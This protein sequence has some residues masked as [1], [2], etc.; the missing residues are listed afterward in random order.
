MA[1][2]AQPLVDM[3]LRSGRYAQRERPAASIPGRIRARRLS[4]GAQ[5]FG[6]RARVAVA[7]PIPDDPESSAVRLRDWILGRLGR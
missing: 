6:T 2:R 1:G 3:H 7:E 4:H 5:F